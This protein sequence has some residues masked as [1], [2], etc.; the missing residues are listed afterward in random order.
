MGT[1]TNVQ[2]RLVALHHLDAPWKPA[3]VEQREG[4]ILRQGNDNKEVAIYRYVTEGSFD[5]YM[6]Q[7]LET[8][9][10]FI[11]QVIRGDNAARRAEDIGGQELSYAEVKAIASGNPAV[12]TLAEADAELQRLSILK[13]NHSDEQFLARRSIR[14]L[15]ATIARLTKRVADLTADRGTLAAHDRD[16]LTI[17]GQ[18]YAEEDAQKPL[19]R[20]L[21]AIPDKTHETRR[22]KLGIYHGLEFGIVVNPLGAPDAYLEGATTRHAMIARDAGP[23]AV[24]NALGRLAD[25]YPGQITTARQDL[26][27]AEGQLRDHQARLGQPFSHEDYL[28]ELT[29]LRD[30]LK[31]GLSQATPEPGSTPVAAL[32]ERI[33][34]LKSAHTIDTAPERTAPRRIAAEEPVTARIRRRTAQEPPTLPPAEPE[35]PVSSADASAGALAKEEGT[36]AAIQEEPLVATIHPFPEPKPFA[37]PQPGYR[38]QHLARRQDARQL[39]L[40]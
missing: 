16:P 19:A 38:Q 26:A 2:K 34:S 18:H 39:T 40:F 9:A 14:E 35:H 15:P 33:K 5:A 7:A 36:A 22:Y 17:A 6:W 13:K 31:A 27:I 23:R 29:D 24:L 21:N 3:E 8:K 37:R 30:Q 28:H 20:Q 4:R 10:R 12:L 32:A 25:T 1:G 11:S